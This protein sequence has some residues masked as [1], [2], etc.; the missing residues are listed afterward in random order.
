M[1]KTVSKYIE[2]IKAL[3]EELEATHDW[4][5]EKLNQELDEKTELLD[6]YVSEAD[7]NK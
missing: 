3:I 4:D 6:R 2:E 7:A 5:I 1:P